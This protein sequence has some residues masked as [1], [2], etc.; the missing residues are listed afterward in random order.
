MLE[1]DNSHFCFLG[2]VFLERVEHGLIKRR[3][4]R[5]RKTSAICETEITQA[6]CRRFATHNFRPGSRNFVLVDA[7]TM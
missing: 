7:G 5:G 3:G 6:I 1:C 2:R 4:L